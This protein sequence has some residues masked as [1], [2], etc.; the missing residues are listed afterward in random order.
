MRSGADLRYDMKITFYEAAFGKEMEIEIPRNVTCDLCKGTGA[1]P[2]TH[3]THC[4][5]CKG[6]GQ[7]TRSQGFY[8]Q[9]H[10]WKLSRRRKYHSKSLQGMPRPWKGKKN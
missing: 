9:L 1:K 2:G 4:P 7:V 5:T 10:L 3:P 6:T 8:N